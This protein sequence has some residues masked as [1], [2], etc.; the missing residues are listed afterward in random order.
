MFKSYMVEALFRAKQAQSMDEVPVGAVIVDPRRGKILASSHNMVNAM[1]DP[2]AHAE[3]LVIRE[4]CKNLKQSR[5]DGL[6]LYTTL[7]PC[8]F[9]AAAISAARINRLYFGAFDKKSGAVFSGVKL[10]DAKTC[11][12]VPEVYAGI[13]EYE[14]LK[15]MQEFFKEKRSHKENQFDQLVENI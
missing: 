8:A 11:H 2:T 12:H 13:C 10:Y 5:L 6:D 1:N 9:C 3:I 7:E 4:V 14:S 15:L